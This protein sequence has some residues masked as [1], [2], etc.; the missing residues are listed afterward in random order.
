M[1]ECDNVLGRIE[2]KEK[3]NTLTRGFKAIRIRARTAVHR[4]A[5]TATENGMIST[6]TVQAVWP[7]T[8]KKNIGAAVTEHCVT[9]IRSDHPGDDIRIA[10]V[11]GAD[12]QPP[13][14]GH[15][16]VEQFRSNHPDFDA[17][18]AD[19]S[20]D[21]DEFNAKGHAIVAVSTPQ[22][23]RGALKEEF[24][25]TEAAMPRV[26]FSENDNVVTPTATDNV[27]T[28][29]E[30]GAAIEMVVAWA[31]EQQVIAALPENE[32][33]A[34]KPIDLIA[35]LGAVQRSVEGIA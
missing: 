18:G 15:E 29:I 12:L 23:S 6:A 20:R 5:A 2:P 7:T 19:Q 32:I 28:A 31:A 30:T 25:V 10:G 21:V 14:K 27:N 33:L 24:I 11:G 35:L 1:D 3:V 8:A 9:E 4:I 13:I 34:R 17:S 22:F 26:A 16:I